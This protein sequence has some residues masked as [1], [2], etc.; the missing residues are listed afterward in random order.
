[1][2]VSEAFNA[3]SKEERLSLLKDLEFHFDPS[4]YTD[5]DEMDLRYGCLIYEVKLEL[6][7]CFVRGTWSGS[8]KMLPRYAAKAPNHPPKRGTSLPEHKKAVC[9]GIKAV[10]LAISYS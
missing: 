1:M 8:A 9:E 10:T 5:W 3:L 7:N 4:Q 2:T 6:A